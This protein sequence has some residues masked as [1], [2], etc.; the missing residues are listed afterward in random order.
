MRAAS[1]C[2][3]V[4]VL[5]YQRRLSLSPSVREA[6]SV[7]DYDGASLSL[8]TICPS[9]ARALFYYLRLIAEP[10]DYI[11]Q[12]R[13]FYTNDLVFWIDIVGRRS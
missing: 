3:C 7:L 12:L 13:C 10:F 5:D 9:S 1:F 6:W 2:S 11:E 8:S 4:E